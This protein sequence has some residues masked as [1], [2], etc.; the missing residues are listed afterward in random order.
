M[1]SDQDD[2]FMDQSEGTT[3]NGS[4]FLGAKDGTKLIGPAASVKNRRYSGT[5]SPV[6]C[7]TWTSGGASTHSLNEADLQVQN[8]NFVLIYKFIADIYF[9]LS[10]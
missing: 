9:F 5:T 8:I 7:S 3:T 1:D 4:V 2:P 6:S 10:E